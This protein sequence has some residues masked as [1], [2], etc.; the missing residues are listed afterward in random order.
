MTDRF[1]RL[2][3][4]AG[5]RRIRLHDV[6]HA[7]ATLSLNS[8]VEPKILSDRVGHSTPAVTFQIYTHRS[9]GL[10]RPAADLIGRMIEEAVRRSQGVAPVTG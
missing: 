4:A 3:D 1:N 6:R 2:V 7:Y 8:G 9:T 5:A 10:D